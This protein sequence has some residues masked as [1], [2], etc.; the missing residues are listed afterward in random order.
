MNVPKGNAVALQALKPIENKT[1]DILSGYVFELIKQKKADDAARLKALADKGAAVDEV[2]SKMDLKIDA[3]LPQFQEG[4]NQFGKSYFDKKYEAER[5]RGDYSPEAQAK[6]DKLILEANKIKSDYELAKGFYANPEINTKIKEAQKAIAENKLYKGGKSYSSF[7]AVMGAPSVA[8][9]ENGNF[10]LYHYEQGADKSIK[11]N[12]TVFTPV[13]D[14]YNNILALEEDTSAKTWTEI[15]K[16][17][18]TITNRTDSGIVSRETVKL[19]EQAVR[20]SIRDM[21]GVDNT[22]PLDEQFESVNE[23]PK[24]TKHLYYDLY[25]K[26]PQSKEDFIGFEDKILNRIKS[27]TNESDRVDR[28][29]PT[30]VNVNNGRGNGSGENEPIISSSVLK[31]Y[32]ADKSG[33]KDTRFY[34]ADGVMMKGSAKFNEFGILGNQKT[35]EVFVQAYWNENGKNANGGKGSIAYGLAIPVQGGTFVTRPLSSKEDP[36]GAKSVQKYFTNT[37][38]SKFNNKTREYFS[39][40]ENRKGY[41]FN[42]SVDKTL[43]GDDTLFQD[44]LPSL[45]NNIRKVNKTQK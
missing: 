20:K 6:K 17:N 14:L 23:L 34:N 1:A 7:L 38:F 18:A 37:E 27:K 15:E 10:G 8:G 32:N 13:G 5:L 39:N 16:L 12:K 41:K 11:D 28:A 45:G 22:K 33:K 25:K 24:E 40:P 4:L 43:Y 30:V 3:T 2:V 44:L 21:L 29:K 36:S 31:L 26:E 35:R 19:K 9:E 42:P